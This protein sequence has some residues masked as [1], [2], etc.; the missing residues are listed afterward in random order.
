MKNEYPGM[1]AGHIIFLT[2][3]T[4]TIRSLNG[5]PKD[6]LESAG[7]SSGDSDSRSEGGREGVCSD[8]GNGD[9]DRGS[10]VVASAITCRHRRFWRLGSSL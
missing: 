1:M 6:T 2:D 3:R 7:V 9:G 10:V 8:G 5:Y 4:D